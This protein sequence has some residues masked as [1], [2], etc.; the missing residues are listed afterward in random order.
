MKAKILKTEEEYETALEFV[1][2]LM[3]AA[4]DTA[5]EEDLDLWSMLVEQYE[6]KHYPIDP[7]E[8]IKFRMDQLGL[9][10]N[11]ILEE[12]RKEQNSKFI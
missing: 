7:I 8:A 11:Y 2:Q 10:Q 4:P 5:E 12:I 3:D 6:A 1:S 9:Q